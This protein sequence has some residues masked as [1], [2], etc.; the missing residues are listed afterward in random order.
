M[1]FGLK[2][3]MCPAQALEDPGVVPALKAWL[4]ARG[5]RETNLEVHG[6]D[7][8]IIES[9]AASDFDTLP[10][11]VARVITLAPSNLELVAHL[12]LGRGVVAC[13]DSSDWPSDIVDQCERLGPDLDPNLDR[14]FE[15]APDLV[16][17][18][19][20]VPGMERVVSGLLVRKLPM[21]V[22]APRTLDEIGDELR[23]LGRALGVEESACAKALA[24][25]QEL[26]ALR[27]IQRGKRPVATYVEWW[28]KPIYVPGHD[29]YSNQILEAAGARN[30]FANREG[31]SLEVSVQD[32][33]DAEPELGLV[34]WCG[35]PFD[36]LNCDKAYERAP[37]AQT[38]M[39]KNR[40]VR[41]IDE[42]LTGR[43]GPRVLQAIV[44][45]AS[46]VEEIRQSS[47][48]ETR[49]TD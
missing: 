17:A 26:A 3:Q 38:P 1:V 44:Q 36:K 14:I 9:I 11:S 8:V 15:L 22:L 39:V 4:I 40:R 27:E 16:V 23:R 24:F 49:H 30:I 12:G 25:E 2:R 33:A 48:R 20:T 5:Q 7:R 45:I 35:V 18:S 34:S 43:P 10:R 13:E 47:E 46:W 42:A 28:P 41:P 31:S 19:L 32:V 6:T 29:C 37:W 21:I